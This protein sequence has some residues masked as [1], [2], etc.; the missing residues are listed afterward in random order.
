M[1]II[2]ITVGRNGTVGI[3]TRY[4]LDGWS[5]N[6]GRARF[7][8]TVQTSPGTHATSCNVDNGYFSQGQSILEQPGRGIYHPPHPAPR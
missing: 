8:A 6:L 7:F 2:I 5:L 3:A 4:G 1:I